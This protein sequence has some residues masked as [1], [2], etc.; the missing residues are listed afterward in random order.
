MEN[1][2]NAAL[3]RDEDPEIWF[4]LDN[5]GPEAEL[6]KAICAACPVRNACLTWALGE[7]AF[8]IAGGLDE[9]ERAAL[10]RGARIS[11]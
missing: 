8:G 5:A 2:R 1:W 4:P 3:C 11:A 6:A 10:R 9:N 7:L